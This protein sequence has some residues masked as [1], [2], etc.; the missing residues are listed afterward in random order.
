[1]ELNDIT[2]EDSSQTE[3]VW[4]EH[5]TSDVS[6]RIA[7]ASSDQY[8]DYVTKRF[9]QARRGRRDLPPETSRR[10]ITDAILK[11]ILKDW[12]NITA[13]G[14]PVEFNEKNARTVLESKSVLAASLRE[15]IVD[16]A[17]N[18]DNFINESGDGAEPMKGES[19]TAAD[20]LKRG[21]TVEATV[22]G[23]SGVSTE[24]GGAGAPS[25]GA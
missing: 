18:P 8:Q 9:N 16:S 10:I 13:D 2:R 6:L 1:M 3:G 11:F 12:K 22:G 7:S 21:P 5:P 4:V 14:K 20:L 15:F 23:G 24:A 19:E 25:P 17:T